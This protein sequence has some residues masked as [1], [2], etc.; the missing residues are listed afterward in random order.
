[1]PSLRNLTVTTLMLGIV[2][3]LSP[4]AMAQSSSADANLKTWDT[5]H[6][7]TLDLTE[8]KQAAAAKF[9]SLDV[10]HDGTLDRKELPASLVRQKAFKRVDS[11]QDVTV[12]KAEYSALVEARFNAAD[13]DHD[14]T[15]SA[16]ELSSKA[17][18]RL[19]KLL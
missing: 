3:S 16:A 9:D 13:T 10:D 7:G 4:F 17:G 15:L 12:D 1:M 6:D 18:K 19:A 11:D 14:G 5:D 8:A 2:C